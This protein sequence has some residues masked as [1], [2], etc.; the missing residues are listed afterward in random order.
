MDGWIILTKFILI[1][2]AAMRFF[3]NA[4]KSP[5]MAV[6]FMLLY[7]SINMLYYVMD[8]KIVK[9]SAL[10]FSAVLTVLC[11]LYLDLWFVILLPVNIYEFIGL[12]GLSTYLNITP[13]IL[14]PIVSGT[15][16]AEYIASALISYLIY[17]LSRTADLKISDLKDRN[18]ELRKNIY[19]LYAR[20]DRSAEHERQVRYTAQLEERNRISQKLHDDIGHTITGSIMQLEA[21]KLLAAKDMETATKMLQNI[22]D[23][24][25]E[26]H[27]SIR[28]ILRDIKPPV[29][30]MGIGGLRFFIDELAA[31][32]TMAIALNCTGDLGRITYAQWGIIIDNVK[33]TLINAIKHSGASK[34]FVNIDVLNKFIKVEVRDNGKGAQVIKE[35]LG[36]RG[37][38]E[39]TQSLGGKVIIDGSDGFSVIFLLPCGDEV[40]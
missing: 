14:I 40:R 4:A 5:S 26:G 18:D 23:V 13:I 15:A 37:I 1:A 38:E 9:N 10:I 16:V 31:K 36:L 29:E 24:L 2:Y 34:A 30:E 8:N 32:T 35:G 17:V 28:L 27:E 12:N 39:R 19:S 11:G 22:I 7:I 25:R 20:L 33:E 21:V 3:S 6:L